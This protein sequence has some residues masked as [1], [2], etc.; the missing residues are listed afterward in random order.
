MT[1]KEALN[2]YNEMGGVRSK[3]ASRD[4]DYRSKEYLPLQYNWTQPGPY[5]NCVVISGGTF[6]AG[7]DWSLLFD[8]ED[9][10]T[11]RVEFRV[12]TAGGELQWIHPEG[13]QG[14]ARMMGTLQV[15]ANDYQTI[16]CLLD[17]NG[18]SS[19]VQVHVNGTR[20]EYGPGALAQWIDISLIPGYN[21]IRIIKNLDTD[22][23][24]FFGRLFNGSHVQWVDPEASRNPVR[25]G[26]SVPSNGTTD[27]GRL[28]V[29]PD[30]PE[31]A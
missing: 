10:P 30:I 12:A 4:L 17:F 19:D 22:D 2:W 5:W 16:P 18:T 7:Q 15:F 26:V 8:S 14:T 21:T 13:S 1:G 31:I 25:G 9:N 23:L 11:N 29:I 3:D 20:T 6:T 24:A 27:P 28:D